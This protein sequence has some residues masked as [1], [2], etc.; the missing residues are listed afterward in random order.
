V[1]RLRQ[2]V[3]GIVAS[4]L[5]V[6]LSLVFIGVLD[7]PVF[8][9]WVSF[10]LVGT[11]AFAFLVALFWRGEHPRSIARLVQPWRGLALLALTLAVAG[12]VGTLHLVTIGGG[13]TPPTPFVAQC[14]ITSVPI[15]FMLMTLWGGW[16]FSLVQSPVLGGVL[17][18]AFA[19]GLNA[20]LFRVLSDFTWLVGAPPYVESLDPKGPVSSWTVLVVLVTAMAATLLLL[21]LDLWP[22]SRWPAL[23]RQP[24]LGIVGTVVAL[25]VALAVV[26]V[27]TAVGLPVPDVLADITAPFLFGSIVVLAMLEGSAFAR[28]S[29]PARGLASAALALL[30]GVVLASVYL[31]LAPS[32]SG[33][34]VWGAPA[35]ELEVW[36]ASA[37]LGVTFPFLS[38]HAD[39]F[40]LWPLRPSEERTEP[41]SPVS[42]P[43]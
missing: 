42:Q 38:F 35:Y 9:D 28:L 16:P 25:A 11:V 27:A 30:V 18:L 12:V 7:W 29:Q 34:L 39:F 32:L 15:A 43:G 19:Y 41:E 24:V 20:L 21:H 6:V 3:L 17:L 31:A 26:R 36:L 5:V 33:D 4:A 13:V 23:M 1:S 14:L 40:R 2:P 22:L 37:L 8:R 10:Y